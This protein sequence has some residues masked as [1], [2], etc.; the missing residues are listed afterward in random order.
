MPP[1]H[2]KQNLQHSR[3]WLKGFRL[4]RLL[5][6]RW[7]I[8]CIPSV[9][10]LQGLVEDLWVTVTGKTQ[11]S[12]VWFPVLKVCFL[13]SQI[14]LRGQTEH[15]WTWKEWEKMRFYTGAKRCSGGF[16]FPPR[17]SLVFICRRFVPLFLSLCPFRFYKGLCCSCRTEGEG[18]LN[19]FFHLP[20]CARA[21]GLFA[22]L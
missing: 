21:G 11:V 15:G 4:F 9:R 10:D 20:L 2:S 8:I 5:S 18:F 12:W 3:L 14:K 16:Q 19:M 1:P 6:P 17:P 13:F 22:N 7:N